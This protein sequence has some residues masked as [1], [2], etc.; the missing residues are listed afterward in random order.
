MKVICTKMFA[1]LLVLV[2]S[3]FLTNFNTFAIV[4][5][6]PGFSDTSGHYAE[7]I[8]NEWTE[9]GHV[10]GF[11]DGTFRPQANVTRAEFVTLLNRVNHYEFSEDGSRPFSDV[12]MGA[13]YYNDV[14]LSAQYGII[15]GYPDGLFVPDDPITRQDVCVM[16]SKCLPSNSNFDLSSINKFIDKDEMAEYAIDSVAAAAA[17]SI[18]NGRPD[19]TLAPQEYITRADAVIVLNNA[20]ELFVNDKEVGGYNGLGENENQTQPLT[21]NTSPFD[22][23]FA[24]KVA[25]YVEDKINALTGTITDVANVSTL[26]LKITCGNLEIV[27]DSI[28]P[29]ANWRYPT[30]N[31]IQGENTVTISAEWN[32]GEESEINIV[33]IDVAGKNFKE[34]Q[35]DTGDNDSDGLLNWQEDILGTDKNN[36]DTDGDGLTDYEEVYITLTNPLMYSTNGDSVSDGKQDFDHDGLDNIQECFYG[37][38]PY[39]ADTDLDGLSDYDEIFV[40]FSNPL[41]ADSDGDGLRDAQEVTYGMDPMNP[42][43]LGDGIPDGDRIF[44]MTIACD[45][46]SE[47]DKVQASLL[48]DLQGKYIDSLSII[49]ISESDYFL[50][51]NIAG[52]FGNAFAFNVDG[53]FPSATIS[54]EFDKSLLNDPDFYPAVYRWDDEAQLLVE[55]PDQHIEG[56]IASVELTSFSKCILLNK[57][58]FEKE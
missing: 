17:L 55:L 35:M 10:S 44:T 53:T 47:E 23:L 30:P 48:V 20:H 29:A 40:H 32:N 13:W 46:L 14:M 3:F 34:H 51:P 2:M 16:I 43:T 27:N 22:P 36:P 26:S 18:F 37:T 5:N 33:L 42:D 24:N 58:L 56:N 54:F 1:L 19:G 28:S 57:T 41:L 50:N 25:F 6:H 52:Y 38:D 9:A 39:G 7:N 12:L 15:T 11:P 21:I 45:D 8:I 4:D 49:K 31:L